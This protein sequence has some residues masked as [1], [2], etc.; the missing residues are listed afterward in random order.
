[1]AKQRRQVDKVDT[2]KK[3]EKT[4]SVD[5][6]IEG[7]RALNE[8]LKDLG[9]CEILLVRPE[10]CIP[11]DVNARYM[12]PEIMQILTQN[13]QKDKRLESMP[14]VWSDPDLPEGKYRIISGHHRIDAAKAAGLKYIMVM[15]ATPDSRDDVVSKQL[16]HNALTGMDDR[17]ILQQLFDSIS[18]ISKRFSTGLQDGVNSVSYTS[19]NFKAGIF[20]E[21]TV[22][23]LP[24]DIKQYDAT[25]DELVNSFPIKGSTTTRIASISTFEDFKSAIIRIKRA[26]NIKSNATALTRLVELATAMMDEMQKENE[27]SS[28]GK[29]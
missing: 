20:K 2:L 12:T 22:L 28:E 14:L 3:G 4:P 13:I 25:M 5:I 18:D 9:L 11:A 27:G 6:V 10:D 17:M 8:Q 1:M 15:L 21:F 29:K 7:L 23:F 26:E 16:S 24:E 19:I